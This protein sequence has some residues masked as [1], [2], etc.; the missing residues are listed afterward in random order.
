MKYYLLLRTLGAGTKNGCESLR[1]KLNLRGRVVATQMP[2]AVGRDAVSVVR[3]SRLLNLGP[4][5]RFSGPSRR[6]RRRNGTIDGK[7]VLT[8]LADLLINE[9]S[10]ILNDFTKKYFRPIFINLGRHMVHIQNVIMND[11]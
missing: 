6:A 5:G 1:S 10:G 2:K 8:I 4:T 7:R 3:P 9:C 11:H